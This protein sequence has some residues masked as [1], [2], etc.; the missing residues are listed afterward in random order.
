MDLTKKLDKK[1]RRMGHRQYAQKK[2]FKGRSILNE[3]NRDYI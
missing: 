3:L 2:L 1:C